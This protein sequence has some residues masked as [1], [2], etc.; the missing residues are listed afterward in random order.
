MVAEACG[1]RTHLHADH[2]RSGRIAFTR[3][4]AQSVK[5]TLIPCGCVAE[6]VRILLTVPSVNVPE[7]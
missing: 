5:C 6:F 2:E 7:R 1:N 4:T 3:P